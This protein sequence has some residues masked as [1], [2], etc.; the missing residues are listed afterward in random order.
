MLKDDLISGVPAM[1]AYSGLKEAEIYHL[2][3][4]GRIP[5]I[6]MGSKIYF[7][8]SEVEAAFKSQPTQG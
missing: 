3:A 7:R 1:A 4:K 6:K 2:V 8:A 5:A